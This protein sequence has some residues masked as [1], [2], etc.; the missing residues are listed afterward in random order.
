MD[1][2]L[3]SRQP[4]QERINTPGDPFNR[5]QWRMHITIEQLMAADKF[6]RKLQTMIARSKRS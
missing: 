1:Q 5:W 2:E 6:N 3:R 4:R